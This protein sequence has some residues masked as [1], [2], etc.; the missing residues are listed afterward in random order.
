M[1]S[2]LAIVCSLLLVGTLFVP[3]PAIG[4]TTARAVCKTCRCC[5]NGAC[6]KADT[7]SEPRPVSTAPTFS[8]SSSQFLALVPRQVAWTLSPVETGRTTACYDAPSF[9]SDLPA[10][11]RNCVR[12]L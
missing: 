5:D 8:T 9:A 10:Y 12:L 1:K 11:A 3:N 6:C 2:V 7:S 4:A